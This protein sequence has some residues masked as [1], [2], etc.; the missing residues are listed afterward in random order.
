M[1]RKYLSKWE[2][3]EQEEEEGEEEEQEEEL[4]MVRRCENMKE[5]ERRKW[6]WEE[7]WRCMKEGEIGKR[8]KRREEGYIPSRALCTDMVEKVFCPRIIQPL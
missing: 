8:R 1:R 3:E 4:V 6:Q 5:E 2:E 7:V